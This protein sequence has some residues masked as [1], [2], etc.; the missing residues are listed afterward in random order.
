MNDNNQCQKYYR[1]KVT[2]VDELVIKGFIPA[3]PESKMEEMPL[4]GQ[5]RLLR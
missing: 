1:I 2:V 5:L 3:V 4:I